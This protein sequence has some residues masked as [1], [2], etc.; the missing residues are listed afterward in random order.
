VKWRRR[1]RMKEARY[2][3]PDTWLVF[4]NVARRRDSYFAF[5]STTLSFRPSAG[6]SISRVN[7]CGGAFRGRGLGGA[8]GNLGSTGALSAVLISTRCRPTAAPVWSVPMTNREKR[9]SAF[10][11]PYDPEPGY[12]FCG[13]PI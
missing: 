12:E 11:L 10:V 3:G 2:R 1:C 5:S 13:E 8:S 9:P 4:A 7:V 6:T